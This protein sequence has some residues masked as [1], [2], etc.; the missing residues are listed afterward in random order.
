MLHVTP[1][2]RT[3]ARIGDSGTT[4]PGPAEL[5]HADRPPSAAVTRNQTARRTDPVHRPVVRGRVEPGPRRSDR[6]DFDAVRQRGLRVPGLARIGFGL[7]PDPARETIDSVEV[8]GGLRAGPEV[9]AAQ[10]GRFR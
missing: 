6:A 7:T 10:A 5:G 1:R 4:A 9:R 8:T 3:A 2:Q